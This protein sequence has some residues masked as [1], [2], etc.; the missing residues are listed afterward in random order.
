MR[1]GWRSLHT[2]SVGAP[3]LTSAYD[4]KACPSFSLANLRRASEPTVG[5]HRLTEELHVDLL[6]SAHVLHPLGLLAPGEQ[7]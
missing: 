1:K 3:V 5:G 2:L 4:L 7:N 6:P